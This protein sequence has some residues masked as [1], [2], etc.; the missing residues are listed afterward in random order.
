MAS[1]AMTQ[2]PV[3]RQPLKINASA[4]RGLQSPPRGRAASRPAKLPPHP[5]VIRADD[6]GGVQNVF[7]PELADGPLEICENLDGAKLQ[8]MYRS[9][10]A[11]LMHPLPVARATPEGKSL[12]AWRELQ[13]VL[14]CSTPCEEGA[15]MTGGLC[16]SLAHTPPPMPDEALAAGNILPL[17]TTAKNREGTC[18]FNLE[19]LPKLLSTWSTPQG[20]GHGHHFSVDVRYGDVLRVLVNEEGWCE[21]VGRLACSQ[22]RWTTIAS[23]QT[24]LCAEPLFVGL[25]IKHTLVVKLRRVQG[26]PEA[27]RASV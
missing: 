24:P 17:T 4:R 15:R 20:C 8:E 11:W 2:L 13:F 9:G 16:V 27:A 3:T 12:P 26:L 18:G 23:W 6:E 25:T 1:L 7:D 10:T 21:V 22:G 5:P 14:T 19:L